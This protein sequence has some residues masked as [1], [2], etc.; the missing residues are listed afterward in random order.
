MEAKAKRLVIVFPHDDELFVDLDDEASCQLFWDQLEIVNSMVSVRA[1]AVQPSPS[2]APWRYHAVVRLGR[3]VRNSV[4]RSAL[5]MM[6]GSD[7]VHEALSF[8]EALQGEKDACV[9]FERPESAAWY[10]EIRES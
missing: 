5:Q 2:G 7:R 8:R 4:E 1:F 3:R 6:L 9:L 10:A